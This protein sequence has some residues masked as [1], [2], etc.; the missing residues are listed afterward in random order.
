MRRGKTLRAGCLI[1]LLPS[2]RSTCMTAGVGW[3]FGRI[4]VVRV[5]ADVAVSLSLSSFHPFLESRVQPDCA[6]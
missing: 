6:P 2:V 5:A 4:R 3:T 1:A